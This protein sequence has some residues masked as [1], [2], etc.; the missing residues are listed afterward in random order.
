MPPPTI[1]ST[2]RPATA[3]RL[4]QLGITLPP[5]PKP[6][7]NFAPGRAVGQMLYLS[8]QGPLTAQG[9]LHQGKVGAQVSVAEAYQHARLTGLNLLAVAQELLGN[10][11]RVCAVVKLLGLVNAAPDFVDHPQV[12]DG[13]SDLLVDV[14]GE[15]IGRGARSALG[16][17][18]LPG[19]QTVE[20]EAIF[21]LY[22]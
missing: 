12:I 14:F 17:A 3:K 5:A 20:I 6:V 9:L 16:M 10:L 13:C 18:S 15:E 7:A 22:D 11:D 1:R 21:A 8:G 2:S 4:Q 19:N